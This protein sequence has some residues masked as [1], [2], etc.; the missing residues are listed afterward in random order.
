MIGRATKVVIY[1]KSPQKLMLL[2]FFNVNKIV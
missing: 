2:T 1:C